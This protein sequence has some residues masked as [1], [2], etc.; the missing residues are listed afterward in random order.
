MTRALVYV[1]VFL[2]FASCP[3]VFASDG[4]STSASLLN[5]SEG[6]SQLLRAR[7]PAFP[8][9]PPPPARLPENATLALIHE[10]YQEL[11]RYSESIGVPLHGKVSSPDIRDR[12]LGIRFHSQRLVDD[13]DYAIMEKNRSLI[14]P[15]AWISN[16]TH[17]SYAR[18]QQKFLSAIGFVDQRN[19]DGM[20]LGASLL[21]EIHR[22]VY[23]G[24]PFHG[25]EGRRLASR[26]RNGE[27]DKATFEKLKIEAFEKN[28]ELAGVPHRSLV[29]RYREVEIDQIFH[30]GSSFLPDGTRYFTAAELK[31]F[32]ENPLMQLEGA[33]VK[34][35][36]PGKFRA[37]FFY[38]DV[39]KVSGAV[40]QVMS[41]ADEALKN[42]KNA[43]EKVA[44]IV[45]LQR[46]LVSIHPFL[47]G[48]GR[49]IRLLGDL[50]YTRNGLPPG[51]RPNNRDLEM[52]AEEAQNFARKNMAEYLNAWIKEF[53]GRVR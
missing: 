42:A 4:S 26:Y 11:L 17:E 21:K 32:Q 10:R 51:L 18:S 44:I 47:D 29:G 8:K 35:I 27:I 19:A 28:K 13:T 2:I 49:T 53:E 46:D 16:P 43:E 20:P 23:D 25:F 52:S 31:A 24:L 15:Y 6:F 33:G 34:E 50:L 40:N 48:N 41:Q 39:K 1:S 5:C 36:S 22:Q 45:R 12:A 14:T 38:H 37:K 7:G 30:G 3:S 9:A